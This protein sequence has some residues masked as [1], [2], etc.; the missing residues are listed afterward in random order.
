MPIGQHVVVEYC[1][2]NC[3]ACRARARERDV[4]VRGDVLDTGLFPPVLI[5][6]LQGVRL[7]R[8]SFG[9]LWLKSNSHGTDEWR[10]RGGEWMT[11]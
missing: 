5:E 11:G 6:P 1:E 4:L 8:L 7:Q 3:L 10:G 9:D 2:F